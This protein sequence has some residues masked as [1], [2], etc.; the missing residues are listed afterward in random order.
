MLAGPGTT[1]S[2][3]NPVTSGNVPTPQPVEILNAELTA[4][5]S[6]SPA[7]SKSDELAAEG[8]TVFVYSTDPTFQS[9]IEDAANG[10]F[11]IQPVED[12]PKL[13]TAVESSR[14]KIVLLDADT[15]RGRV[16][17]RI[18]RLR[19]A[20]AWSVIV[21][22]ASRERAPFLMELLWQK[23]I[24]RLVI[25]PLGCGVTRILIESS[26]ARYR[27]LRDDPEQGNESRDK[28]RKRHERLA[29]LVRPRNLQLMATYATLLLAV[30]IMIGGVLLPRAGPGEAGPVL[31]DASAAAFI[32]PEALESAAI[33]EQLRLARQARVEGR[34]VTP[35]GRSV[36]DH[37][38]AV[39]SYD[40]GNDEATT[41]LAGLLGKLFGQAESQL[42]ADS[43]D[44]AGLTLDHIRRAQPESPRLNFLDQ[45]L[46]RARQQALDAPE[47]P[48]FDLFSSLPVV[49]AIPSL[50]ELDSLLTVAD[51]RLQNR[52]LMLPS[53]DSALDY[54]RRAEVL[55]PDDPI[56]LETR[57]ELGELIS[58]SARAA[59]ESGNLV[60]AERRIDAALDLGAQAAPLA[61][62]D[63]ELAA[64]RAATAA[65]AN[66][67]RLAAL[68]ADGQDR[69]EQGRLIAPEDDSA[70][71]FLSTLS[72]ER[73]DYPD[74]AASMQ[75]LTDG[76]ASNAAQ[77]IGAG[78][79]A[80]G[81]SWL[82]SLERVGEGPEL[83]RE[84][85]EQLETR[86]LQERYLS[87]PGAPSELVLVDAAPLEYPRGAQQSSIEG[88]VDLEFIVGLDGY[89]A[90][91]EVVGAEPAGTFEQAAIAS[92]SN[93]RYEP[94]EF[95]GRAY[96][97]RLSLR[98]RFALE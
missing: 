92:V 69:L 44:L 23:R 3:E 60:D 53:G 27:Q 76:L 51:V 64:I 48:A 97:R 95:D 5:A 75:R 36:L 16:E 67:A 6:V 42:L 62:L 55:S 86:R 73:P 66:T 78:D 90:E 9:A 17:W 43:L 63:A 54:L 19:A 29:S 93:Y 91:V 28:E 32:A 96:A 34:L 39:L 79:W 12:W 18:T 30:A 59:L 52:Q 72:A 74:L 20:A 1:H 24:H 87:V 25:K 81:E 68:F 80:A 65:D 89:V 15:M 47:F 21:I 2:E 82:A 49:A 10:D 58:A 8:A 22:A 98:V 4:H 61:A 45:Q 35:E 94:F 26:V 7:I 70:Y 85:R 33:T 88:W 84:L 50:T 40:A 83:R 14:C 37:Y 41:E 77:A 71:Y 13:V 38:A 56:V 11:A 46:E 31:T 57:A